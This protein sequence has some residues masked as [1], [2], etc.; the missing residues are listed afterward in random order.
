MN[1]GGRVL[2]NKQATNDR[3]LITGKAAGSSLE[4][5]LE[6]VATMCGRETSDKLRYTIV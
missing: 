1:A 4:F 6:L 2:F 3:N 5:A